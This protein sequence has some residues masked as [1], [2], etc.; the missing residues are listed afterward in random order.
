MKIG[1]TCRILIEDGTRKEFVNEAYMELINKYNFI[2]IVLSS[3]TNN[4][5]KLLD[6]CDCFLLP[7]GDDMDSRYFNEENDPHN[8]L[9]D[10]KI[11]V[12]DYR[13]I[14]YALKN[15]KP[16]LGICR[17]LQVLNVYFGGNLIQHIEDNSHKKN[18]DDLL[19]LVENSSLKGILKDSF[20][21]NSFHHQK[22]GKLGDGI[23]VEGL[24]K[25][26]VELITHKK[27]KI[28]ATQYHI[29]QLEDEN[30]DAIMKYFISLVMEK[31]NK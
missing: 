14:D 17:G 27:F 9:V 2:P 28:I 11:D 29:E 24:S 22:I 26:V 25:G 31:E 6:M 20:T 7:G 21:I 16:I 10:P 19:E 12:L 13:V 15:N 1:I 3:T 23:V 5:E 18:Y 8:I 4:I 30:T